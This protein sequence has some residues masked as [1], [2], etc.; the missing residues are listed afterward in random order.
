MHH[1]E[2]ISKLLKDELSHRV[3]VGQN[4]RNFFQHPI[5]SATYEKVASYL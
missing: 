4:P 5:K 2:T 1:I 3:V